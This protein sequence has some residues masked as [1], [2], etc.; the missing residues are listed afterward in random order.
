MTERGGDD[1]HTWIDHAEHLV[2]G[3]GILPLLR[4]ALDR[5]GHPAASLEARLQALAAEGRRAAAVKDAAARCL[6]AVDAQ[7]RDLAGQVITWGKDVRARLGAVPRGAPP[8]APPLRGR[9]SVPG[10]PGYSE[11]SACGTSWSSRGCPCTSVLAP[12][13]PSG[14]FRCG[15]TGSA[16]SATRWGGRRRS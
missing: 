1:L 5:T 14:P 2:E 12:P 13:I 10:S 4:A 16:T 9:S 6:D 15:R 3:L 11:R 7:A 8:E